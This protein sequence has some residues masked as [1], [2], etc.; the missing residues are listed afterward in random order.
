[1]NQP[2]ASS[3]R[4]ETPVLRLTPFWRRREW[5]MWRARYLAD[6]PADRRGAWVQEASQARSCLAMVRDISLGGLKVQAR[7]LF[8]SGTVLR[9]ELWDENTARTP[10]TMQVRVIRVALRPHSGEYLY[11]CSFCAPESAA[12]LRKIA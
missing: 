2:P 8:E 7:H 6:T 4:S 3:H 11:T 1:M 9:V 10:Q 5:Q 12:P